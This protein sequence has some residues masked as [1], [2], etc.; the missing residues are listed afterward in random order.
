[1][2]GQFPP[3][4][5]GDILTLVLLVAALLGLARLL[6][7]LARRFGQPAVVGEIMAGVLV[8]PSLLGAVPVIG[9]I[10]LPTNATQSRL[11]DVVALIGAMLL[12]ALTGLETDLDLIRR[13]AK[14][15]FGVAAGGL[16][17]PFA[18]GLLIAGAF[19]DD[20]LG[21]SA[22]RPVFALFLAVALAVSAIPVL[23]TILMELRMMRRNVGQT[24]LA[25][26]MIDDLAGWAILGV[27]V[28]LTEANSGVGA[29]AGTLVTVFVF[30]GVTALLGP[31]IVNAAVVLVHTRMRSRDRLLTLAF[32][33]IFAWGAF[34]QALHLEAVIG[35]FAMGILLGRSRRMPV[36][37]NLTIERMALAVFSPIFFA[38]A[39]L[40]VDLGVLADP[41]L[42]ALTAL[43]VAVAIVGKLAGAYAG[44]RWLTRTDRWSALAF[45]VGLTARGAI[46]IVIAT[47]GLSLGVFGPEVFSMIVIMAVVTSLVTPP[48]LT[49]ILRRIEPEGEE[50]ERLRREEVTGT[51]MVAGISQVLL[52]V[53]PRMAIG[54][55]LAVKLGIL[56]RLAARADMAVTVLSSA[57]RQER[58]EAERTVK[59][60]SLGL[61]G[62]ID[63]TTKVVDEG[64]PAAVVL[65]ELTSGYDLLVVGSPEATPDG[66]LLFG[67]TIDEVVRLAGTPTLV[68]RG[69]AEIETWEPRSILVPT[70]GSAASQRAA[71]LAFTVAGPEA[72]VSLLHVVP[73]SSGLVDHGRGS[74]AE[75]LER[76]HEIVSLLLER[77]E[78]MGVQ[79]DTLVEYGP[80]PEDAIVDVAHRIGADLVVLGTSVR[81]GTTRLYL[82]TRVE[83]VLGRCS[84]PVAVLNT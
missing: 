20:L 56:D 61:D 32:V 48:A 82:G 14:T 25:A 49:S 4:S 80:N 51:S 76:G 27:V 2:D 59:R 54:Q 50:L 65:D 74:P 28:A 39:G 16:V 15:A 1:V 72:T 78:A 11:I 71:E 79:V 6:G 77:G 60:V 37:V 8:G 9:E 21:P 17:L 73:R 24:M 44:G 64:D 23:A 81:A 70:D 68:V 34:S 58:E 29:I 22:T 10:L 26:G 12:L 43:I 18:G 3:A 31:R 53:R 84:A 41:R 67:P 46:G 69:G 55:S 42:A 35:A 7:E 45:G 5:H 40:R 33:L 47:I 75:R 62:T 63:V 38:V 57:P 30:V 66:E 13:R 19:A 52:P 36:E 83:A